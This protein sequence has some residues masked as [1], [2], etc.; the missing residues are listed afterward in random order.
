ML[1]WI[2]ILIPIVALLCQ[3]RSMKYLAPFSAMGNLVYVFAISV[4]FYDGFHTR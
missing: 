4:V 3:V 2:F 1:E